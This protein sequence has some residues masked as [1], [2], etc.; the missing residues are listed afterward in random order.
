M[1][2]I[3][4]VVEVVSRDASRRNGAKIKDAH[5]S[6]ARDKL[7]PHCDLWIQVQKIKLRSLSDHGT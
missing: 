6:R 5:N 7:T 2:K 1:Q 4:G 3:D